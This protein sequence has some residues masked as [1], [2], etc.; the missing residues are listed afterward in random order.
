MGMEVAKKKANLPARQLSLDKEED[1]TKGFHWWPLP[2]MR[3]FNVENSIQE[4]HV[5][6][7]LS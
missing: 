4:L 1:P 3:K 2:L 6:I 5:G 7:K